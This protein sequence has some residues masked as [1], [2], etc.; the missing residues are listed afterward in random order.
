MAET[1]A[2]QDQNKHVIVSTHQE[3]LIQSKHIHI[4]HQSKR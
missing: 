3:Q 4:H 1:Q 2:W